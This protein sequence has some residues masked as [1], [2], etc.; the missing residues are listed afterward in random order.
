LALPFADGKLKGCWWRK[1]HLFVL[2]GS[3]LALQDTASNDAD[4]GRST[5]QHGNAAW[6]MARF[7]ALAE[8]GTHLIFQ[9]ELG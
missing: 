4:F 1:H 7:V 5:N 6:P 9:A 2:H 8:V 3:T